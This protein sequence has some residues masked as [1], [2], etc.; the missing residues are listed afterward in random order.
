MSASRG[1]NPRYQKWRAVQTVIIRI[2]TLLN[3]II[4]IAFK[5]LHLCA[6]KKVA[7]PTHQIQLCEPLESESKIMQ[8]IEWRRALKIREVAEER[9]PVT[10]SSL[11]A[12]TSNNWVTDRQA[13]H[14]TKLTFR[15]IAHSI[16]AP[17]L[18]T[19]ITV[20]LDLLAAEPLIIS[21]EEPMLTKPQQ[22]PSRVWKGNLGHPLTIRSHKLTVNYKAIASRLAHCISIWTIHTSQRCPS[23][24]F[25]RSEA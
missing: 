23:R 5:S 2:T 21:T 22:L 7:S 6:I 3:R 16:S 9:T 12:K 20:Q 1:E 17:L 11:L 19:E 8:K 15:I 25:W 4:V 10:L 24:V 14:Q 18:P 13:S